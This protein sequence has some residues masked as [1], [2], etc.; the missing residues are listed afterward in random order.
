VGQSDDPKTILYLLAI[1]AGLYF[2]RKVL[3]PKN[4]PGDY[5]VDLPKA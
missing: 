2:F 1:I 5:A 3:P 4:P